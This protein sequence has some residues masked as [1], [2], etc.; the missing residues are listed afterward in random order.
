MNRR[1]FKLLPAIA[2]TL[3]TCATVSLADD[4]PASGGTVE[5]PH[6]LLNKSPRVVA[7][8]L[9]R[10]SNA[11]LVLVDRN[12]DDPKYKPVYE[13]IL[14]RKG[15]D[16]KYRE[17]AAKALAQ[18]D[19]SSPVVVLL[20]AIGKA[21]PADKSTPRELTGMLMAQKPVDLAL[22]W[23][24][25]KSLA[26][27]S[28]NPLVRQA[29]YAAMAAV[30]KSPD[31][32]WTIATAKNDVKDLMAAIP[33]IKDG[34]RRSAFFD[35]VN[36]LVTS[37]PDPATQ[38]AAIDAVSSMPGHEAEAFKELAGLIGGGK[39]EVRDAAVHSIRRV[40]EDKWPQ[41]QIEPLA[42]AVVKLVK[43]TPADQRTGPQIGQAVQ[44]GN[45]LAGELEDAKAQAIRKQLRELAVPIVVVRTLREQMQF[46]TK[47]FVV[48][49]GKPVEVT[50]DN[51]DAM[52][53]NLVITVPGAMQEVAVAAGTMPPPADDTKK[54]Y[55]PD[56]PK[57]LESLS[58]VQPDESATMTFTA[59][60]TPGEYDFV[61]TFPGHWVRMY[62]VMLVVP[63]LEAWEKN[64]TPPKD[65]MTHKAYESQKNEA[66]GAMA[67][68]GQ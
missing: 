9:K 62:G 63:D 53:H 28:Q 44:L 60:K 41:E 51:G 35:K 15:M 27:E 37:A 42:N 47:Y 25:L 17:E 30:A 55:V 43:D 58:M 57:V 54:A 13:A 21:D 56:S 61:C 11:Q 52:P 10:L 33:L 66:T 24:K 18:L 49:A 19:K 64:P 22:Q 40:P 65:P 67:G 59:P 31:E 8:Q 29:A 16:V 45:D 68:M 5:K 50:L 14:T 48:Q 34:T 2:L 3:G 39:G 12:A 7:Y 36:P 6:V 38:V 26:K 23:N 20:D 1:I 4:Q 32:L 46:D